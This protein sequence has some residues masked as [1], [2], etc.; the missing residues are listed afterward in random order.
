M[1]SCRQGFCPSLPCVCVCLLLLDWSLHQASF[2]CLCCLSVWHT[3]THFLWCCFVSAVCAHSTHSLT[4]LQDAI[5][6][7]LYKLMFKYNICNINRK[8]NHVENYDEQHF[9]DSQHPKKKSGGGGSMLSNF[10]L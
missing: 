6:V 10:S 9:M 2:S 4:H 5:K 1:S 3:H 7:L 8:T